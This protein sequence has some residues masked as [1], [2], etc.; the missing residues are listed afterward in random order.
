MGDDV[1]LDVER[2][3]Q[4]P[5]LPLFH[6]IVGN[7]EE[8]LERK[9]MTQ[10]E[11]LKYATGIIGTKN[12]PLDMQ[13]SLL[14]IGSTLPTQP[15][16]GGTAM[17][18]GATIAFAVRQLAVGEPLKAGRT[19]V[20]LEQTLVSG[21]KGVRHRLKHRSHSRMLDNAMKKM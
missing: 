7:I 8:M 2:F 13:K 19:V 12:V 6:G 11:W 1:M 18:A 10:R 21:R 16:L 4:D 3:D 5:N 14:K 20:S 17:A 9:N 15:Q